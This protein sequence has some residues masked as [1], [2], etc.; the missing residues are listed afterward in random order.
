[1]SVCARTVWMHTIIRTP[2]L[3]VVTESIDHRDR[4]TGAKSNSVLLNVPQFL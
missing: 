2:I 3:D 4:S 1:M